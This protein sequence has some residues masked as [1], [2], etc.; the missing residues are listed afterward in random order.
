MDADRTLVPSDMHTYVV[1][2][3]LRSHDSK[4]PQAAGRMFKSW[5]RGAV[6]IQRIVWFVKVRGEPGSLHEEMETEVMTL[7]R[8]SKEGTQRSSEPASTAV[9]TLGFPEPSSVGA[10]KRA[11]S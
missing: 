4:K 7:S 10:A 1:S 6:R 3:E 5:G 2:Q 11:V 8:I 9:Y